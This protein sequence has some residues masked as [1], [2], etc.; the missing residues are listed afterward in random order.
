MTSGYTIAIMLNHANHLPNFQH[1]NPRLEIEVRE[2]GPILITK[3]RII[4]AGNSVFRQEQTTESID[5]MMQQV[6]EE[7]KWINK[8]LAQILYPDK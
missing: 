4:I 8:G 5:H 3:R 2:E 7:E 6:L 1:T